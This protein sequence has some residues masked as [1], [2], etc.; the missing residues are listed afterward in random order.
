MLR[1]LARL[2]LSLL[3]NAIGL[4]VASV[5]LD[6]FS[7]NDSSFLVAVVIFSLATTI[8]SPLIIKIALSSAPYLM[9][10]VA[11]VTTIVGL[12]ITDLFTNGL[13]ISGLSTWV[14]AT[15]IIWLSSILANLVLPLIIFK[16]LLGNKKHKADREE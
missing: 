4:L 9:G 5:L 13:S 7:I 2:V 1:L 11:L 15:L 16:E 12:I 8:L 3:A 14:I 10:G 6:N